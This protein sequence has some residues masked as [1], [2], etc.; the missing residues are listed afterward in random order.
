MGCDAPSSGL[1]ADWPWIP[2]GAP[3]WC[4]VMVASMVHDPGGH[5]FCVLRSAGGLQ[6]PA[7]AAADTGAGAWIG[8][9][10]IELM[11]VAAV[12]ADP[13]RPPIF[14]TSSSSLAFCVQ[15]AHHSPHAAASIGEGFIDYGREGDNCL[16]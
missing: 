5:A 4:P 2:E 10:F 16:Y 9:G 12:A 6:L 13:A 14:M 1:G 15:G 3:D 8:E 7:L 11:I